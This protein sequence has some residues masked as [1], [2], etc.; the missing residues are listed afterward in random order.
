MEAIVFYPKNESQNKQVQLFANDSKISSVKLS[1][2][3]TRRLAGML[4]AN[5]ANNNPNAFATDEEI[6]SVVEEVRQARYG[7]GI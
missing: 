4:L 3:E 6:I 5:L 2:E 7:K 1:D